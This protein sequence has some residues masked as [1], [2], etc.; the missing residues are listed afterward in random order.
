L[1]SKPTWSPLSVT[2]PNIRQI[3][4]IVEPDRDPDGS[5]LST[6]K[7]GSTQ[8]SLF[9]WYA[10]IKLDGVL[11]S[12][13]LWNKYTEDDWINENMGLTYEYLKSHT[14]PALWMKVSEEYDG[15]KSEVNGGPFFLYLLIRQLMADNDSIS[16]ALADKIKGLRISS[17]KGEDVDEVVTHLRG[18]IHRLKNMRR[19]D[20]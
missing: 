13:Y 17:Y 4:M 12:N 6:L 14:A 5:I 20:Q 18:I 7:A 15:H 3:F 8:R 2:L 1:D 9:Q 19:R 16:V 11:A 10:V